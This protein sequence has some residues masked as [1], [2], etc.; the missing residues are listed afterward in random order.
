[1]TVGDVGELLIGIAAVWSAVV[2]THNAKA[3]GKVEK[4][5]DGIVKQ[6]VDSTAA[7]SEATGHAEGRAEGHAAGLEQGRDER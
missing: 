1:M 6:L 3:L 2:G 4:A 5:T 7:A